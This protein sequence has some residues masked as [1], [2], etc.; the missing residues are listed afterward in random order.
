MKNPL[1]LKNMVLLGMLGL[2]L[3]TYADARTWTNNNGQEIEAELL[4]VDGD[5][6][7]LKLT[8]NRQVYIIPIATLSEADQ[9]FIAEQKVAQEKAAAA[10]MLDDRKGEWTEDWEEAQE[11][12]EALGLPILLLM[13]GS[14]W[15]GPCMALEANVFEEKDFQRFAARNL[16]LMKADFPRGSQSRSIQKQNAELKKQYPF[17]G[18]PTVFIL[19]SDLKQVASLTGFG[20]GSAEDYIAKLEAK[21]PK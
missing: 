14:D 17:G 19:D 9:T 12:A 6:V 11:Q 15:C 10:A 2:P 21:L 16:V 18:Y 1:S 7:R 8:S 20:G 4:R 5:E 3:F 13:T